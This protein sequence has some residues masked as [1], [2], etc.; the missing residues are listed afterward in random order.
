MQKVNLNDGRVGP[1]LDLGWTWVGLG[2]H[3]GWTINMYNKLPHRI[4]SPIGLDYG[5]F[6][7]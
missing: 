1:G 2:L 7:G 5:V 4:L 6:V 3:L